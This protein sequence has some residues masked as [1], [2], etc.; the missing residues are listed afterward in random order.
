M[1][2]SSRETAWLSTLPSLRFSTARVPWSILISERRI[3]NS[4][5]VHSEEKVDPQMVLGS[6]ERE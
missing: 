4:A 1:L 5:D 3:K 6:E 2:S